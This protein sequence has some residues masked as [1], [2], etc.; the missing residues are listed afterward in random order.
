MLYYENKSYDNSVKILEDKLRR[1]EIVY[2]NKP[3][4]YVNI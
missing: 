2:K 4:Y 3:E 1:V